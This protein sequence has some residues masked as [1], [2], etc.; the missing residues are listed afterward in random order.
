MP[1]VICLA[2]T[3]LWDQGDLVVILTGHMRGVNLIAW[4]V[5]CVAIKYQDR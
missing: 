3:R 4:P 5:C 1:V 2:I